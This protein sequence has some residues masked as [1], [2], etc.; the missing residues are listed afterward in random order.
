MLQKRSIRMLMFGDKWHVRA[1]TRVS[2]FE[3][4]FVSGEL[5]N[6]YRKNRCDRLQR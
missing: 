3:D 1:V 6:G 4:D 2:S 5:Q